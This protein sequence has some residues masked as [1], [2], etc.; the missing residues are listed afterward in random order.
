MRLQKIIPLLFIFSNVVSRVFSADSGTSLTNDAVAKN[1]D[2]NNEVKVNA[3]LV[4]VL[5][6]ADSTSTP[7]LTNDAVAKNLDDNEVKVKTVPVEVL[8]VHEELYGLAMQVSTVSYH[9]TISSLTKV[10]EKHKDQ[11]NNNKVQNRT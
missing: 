5:H 7:P 9:N 11:Q 10:T 8:P 3:A 4:E 2:D 1:L 6:A